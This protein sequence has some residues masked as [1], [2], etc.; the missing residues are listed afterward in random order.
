[1]IVLKKISNEL[2]PYLSYVDAIEALKTDTNLSKVKDIEVP[3]AWYYE[4]VSGISSIL[5]KYAKL[6]KDADKTPR[7]HIDYEL[8]DLFRGMDLDPKYAASTEFWG[9]ITI[10][11]NKAYE[12]V[13]T[14]WN[15][16][17]K[18]FR[19]KLKQGKGDLSEYRRYAG[20]DIDRQTYARIWWISKMVPM[21]KKDVVFKQ[22]DFLDWVIMNRYVLWK[23]QEGTHLQSRTMDYLLDSLQ[24]FDHLKDIE[25]LYKSVQRQDVTRQVLKW[26]KILNDMT[27]IDL[28]GEDEIKLIIE[29]FFAKAISDNL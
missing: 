18:W 21:D 10:Q 15:H 11:N 29:N 24:N 2:V 12:L 19:T 1:M 27:M 14:R 22:Q 25:G 9:S 6:K 16:K 26:L 7:T 5:D 13:R 8:F 23:G 17:K 28:F 3:E 20:N 4:F